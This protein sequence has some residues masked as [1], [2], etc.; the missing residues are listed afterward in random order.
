[1]TPANPDLQT[2]SLNSINSPVPSRF[3]G[4]LQLLT[5]L[6][7]SPQ[8]RDL[9]CIFSS[10][11]PTHTK[12][13][14]FRANGSASRRSGRSHIQG[15]SRR[16]GRGLRRAAVRGSVPTVAE[17]VCA[18]LVS[19]LLH[20]ADFAC[21]SGDVHRLIDA[22]NT[23][24]AN[25]EG[26]I[27]NTH[28]MVTTPNRGLWVGGTGSARGKS[29][30]ACRGEIRKTERGTPSDFVLTAEGAPCEERGGH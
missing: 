13:S 24:N 11:T 9:S 15:L 6:Y 1:M 23:A 18:R 8:S 19:Q 16:G 20:A 17:P 28:R 14:T 21:S 27:F 7:P 26:E 2:A 3:L 22:I 10:A 29:A 5:G 25:G 30:G 12:P 4:R